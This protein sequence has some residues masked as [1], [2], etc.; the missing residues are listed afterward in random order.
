MSDNNNFLKPFVT[1]GV[2]LNEHAMTEQVVGTCPFCGKAKFFVNAEKGLWDCKVCGTKGN[3]ATF[4]KRLWEE[5]RKGNT[6]AL[7]QLARDRKLLLDDTLEAWGVVSSHSTGEVLVPGHNVESKLSNLYR[8]AKLPDNPAKRALFSTP[9]MNQA[10]F[11]MMGYDPTRPNVYLCEGPWDGMALW[12]VLKSAKRDGEQLGFTGAFNNSLAIGANVLAAP[13]ANVFQDAWVPLFANKN[14]FILYD[15]DHPREHNGRTVDGAGI[16]GVRR[17]CEHLASADVGD[18]P[19]S[20]NYLHWGEETYHD[21]ALKSGYD[22]R[23]Y[24]TTEAKDMRGRVARLSNLFQKL[25]PVPAEWLTARKGAGLSDV[26]PLPCADWKTLSNSWRKAM[27]WSA[28]L[29]RA[30]SVMLACIFSVETSGDQLW[31]KIIGPAACGKSTLCEAVSVA[32]KYVLA[33]STIR[34]FHSGF[35]PQGDDSGGKRESS[36]I[37]D[38]TNKT[39]VTKD[40]DTLLTA[41][42]LPQI[43]A[44]ARDIYDRTSR[45]HYRNQMGRDYQGV[46]MTWI[47]AGTSSLRGIDSSELGERFIDCV[48]MQGINDDEEEAIIK[49]HT[50]KLIDNMRLGREGL[51]A[52]AGMGDEQKREAAQL[53]GGYIEH[54]K[55]EGYDALAVLD[56]DEEDERNV[57]GYAKLVAYLRARPSENQDE[58][59]EREF[60][61]RLSS[62]LLR[63]AMCMAVVRNSPNLKGTVMDYVRQVALDTARGVTFDIVEYLHTCGDDGAEAKSMAILLNQ[64]ENEHKERLR[65]LKRIGALETF[66]KRLTNNFTIKG[67]VRWKLT[68]KMKSLWEAVMTPPKS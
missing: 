37:E 29:D 44:E 51:R 28:G 57:L 2:D 1:H 65:F 67:P 30:L 43:L 36:L 61:T 56:I 41:P 62:Q 34:G 49:R 17:V 52:T 25:K 64:T 24:L 19:S 8:Y 55:A 35:K 66:S 20:V 59:A 54:L 14:V 60:G 32:K 21:P 13:G 38:V 7:K 63:L 16:A 33:K 23:D 48:I 10:L 18:R 45:T 3:V 50:S 9:K 27:K 47:L 46:N 15:N 12:E 58:N 22:V 53:T 39:L 11:G 4:L 26:L 40:G 42:N 6:A 68:P 5:S 31:V